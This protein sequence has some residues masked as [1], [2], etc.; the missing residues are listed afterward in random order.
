MVEYSSIYSS[1]EGPS[2]KP[3]PC[4]TRG[5]SAKVEKVEKFLFGQRKVDYVL[6][7]FGILVRQS[8]FIGASDM[9][10]FAKE[11]ILAKLNFFDIFEKVDHSHNES[12][13]VQ[14]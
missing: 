3:K 13:V 5:F 12:L 8:Q 2:T 10:M 7:I 6:F 1:C 9:G 4:F 14:A 11:R